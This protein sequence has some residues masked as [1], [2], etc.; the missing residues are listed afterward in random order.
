M[1]NSGSTLKSLFSVA[2]NSDDLK[3]ELDDLP[4]ATRIAAKQLVTNSPK[5]SCGGIRSRCFSDLN[6]PLKLPVEAKKIKSVGARTL[7]W[8]INTRASIWATASLFKSIRFWMLLGAPSMQTRTQTDKTLDQLSGS[9]HLSKAIHALSPKVAAWLQGKLIDLKLNESLN[10]FLK[11]E[12]C[13]LQTFVDVLLPTIYVNIA[14]NVKESFEVDKAE[15]RVVSLAD[16]AAFICEIVDRHLPY[17]DQRLDIIEKTEEGEKRNRVICHVFSRVI[18]EF[19]TI[20]LPNGVNEL[21]I[22]KV[23]VFSQHFWKVIQKQVLPILF[24]EV[25]RQLATPIFENRREILLQKPGGESLVSLAHMAGEQASEILPVFLADASTEIKHNDVVVTHQ[26][27]LLAA[28]GNN[29]SA[30]LS[31]SDL[32]KN[33]LSR[34]F[35]KELVGFGKS[36]NADLKKLWMLLGSYLEPILIHIFIN[37]SEIKVSLEEITGRI[38]DVMGIILIR[39]LSV[40]SKFFN[41]NDQK[42]Q[43]RIRQLQLSG[44]DPKEDP[45]V[46]SFFKPLAEDLLCLMGLFDPQELPLPDFIKE[47]VVL[48]LKEMAPSFLLRQ[49]FAVTNST[50]DDQSTRK[51]LRSL[52]FDPKNLEDPKVAVKVITAIHQQ[53]DTFAGNLFNEFYYKLWQESGTERIAETFEEICSVLASELVNSVMQHFGVS[54]QNV[55]KIESNIFMKNVDIKVKTFVET[56][57]LEIFVHIMETVEE[58][59]LPDQK[60]HPK[61]LVAIN[62]ILQVN[63]IVEKRLHGLKKE[64][65]KIA[66]HHTVGSNAYNQEVHKLFEDLAADLHDFFGVNPF[67]HLPLEEFPAGESLK[68]ILWESV[69]KSVLP[70]LAHKM[71][72]E[73]VDWQIQLQNSYDELE[74]SYHTSH[75]KWACKVLAQYVTDFIRHFLEN[76]DKEVASLLFD[77]LKTYFKESKDPSAIS[78]SKALEEIQSYAELI[79]KQNVAAIITNNDPHFAAFWPSLTRYSEAVIAKFFAEFSKTIREIELENPDFTVDIAIQLLKDITD[80]FAVVTKMTEESGFDQSFRVPLSDMLSAFGESLHDGIPL[81]PSDPESLKDL[82]RLQGCFIPLAAKLLK[83]ANLAVK[84]FPIP[85]AVRQPIGELIVNKIFPLVLL[86]AYQKAFEPQVRNVLMLNFIQTLYAALNGIPSEKRENELEEVSSH[87]NPKQKHLYETCGFLILELIK[88]IPDTTVQYVFMKEK[89]KN[90]SAEAVGDAIMPYLSK[91]TLLQMIDTVIYS[92]LPSFHPSKWEGKLGREDL[93]P[94]KAFV[95]PD[96]KMELKPVKDFK[97]DFPTNPLEI[98]ILKA[99]KLKEEEKVRRELRDGFTKTISQQLHAKV[100]SFVKSLWTSLQAQL[101]DFVERMFPDKGR[102]IKAIL[103]KIFSRIFFDILGTIVLFLA[104]PLVSLIKYFIEKAVID[105]R[106]EDVI[107]NLQSEVLENLFYK[108]TD[109]VIDALLNLH[110]KSSAPT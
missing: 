62:A 11:D 28:I 74:K 40:C 76:S 30:L 34:W 5:L 81:N 86:R 77:A 17:I 52:L 75:A 2:H 71:Y 9:I 60:D 90:M 31:G 89:V 56:A 41:A 1:I 98:R 55:L 68:G 96:G 80:H 49:Y 27:P 37:M 91:W 95:R 33:W 100:W 48:Q 104:T 70:D 106:S 12:H 67:K 82:I 97:F 69:K 54:D 45:V 94:R 22:V 4:L 87:P 108:W 65:T 15:Q 42:I 79:L 24:Y 107:E 19:L 105:H 26:S 44:Q 47:T 23:P 103:D 64:L 66:L 16:V 18:D 35:I 72:L 50:I 59:E 84:D 109:S 36:D 32:L 38:P 83:L 102:E 20:A 46:L 39:L 25:Y 14:K 13:T 99:Q 93:V 85:S 51:K 57:F 110:Q 6:E 21:P 7:S 61:C 10:A 101:N 58:K 63:S 73:V 8:I 78:V 92:G 3:I 88:L 43:A 53:K 29:F